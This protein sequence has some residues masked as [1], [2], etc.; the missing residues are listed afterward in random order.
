MNRLIQSSYQLNLQQKVTS[1][2][3]EKCNKNIPNKLNNFFKSLPS[4]N[5]N[6]YTHQT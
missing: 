6:H 3:E 4:N 2:K 5:T 1:S